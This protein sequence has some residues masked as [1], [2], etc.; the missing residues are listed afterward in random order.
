M[1]EPSENKTNLSPPQP[2]SP[3]DIDVSEKTQPLGCVEWIDKAM[4]A[5]KTILEFAISNT[6][7]CLNQIK[8]T[9]SSSI[10]SSLVSLIL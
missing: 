4:I 5:P 7:S 3:V 8:S 1:D 2:P 10:K 9:S 6:T